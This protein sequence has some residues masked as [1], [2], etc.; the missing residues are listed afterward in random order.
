MTNI[1]R[2]LT[3]FITHPQFAEFNIFLAYKQNSIFQVQFQTMIFAVNNKFVELHKIQ[4]SFAAYP[5]PVPTMLITPKEVQSE[6]FCLIVINTLSVHWK[7]FIFILENPNCVPHN[8]YFDLP[9]SD[10]CQNDAITN[11]LE[12]INN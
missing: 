5:T 4:R 12:T 9:K 2:F 7:F 10:S 3:I 11:E 1:Y 6:K 8:I